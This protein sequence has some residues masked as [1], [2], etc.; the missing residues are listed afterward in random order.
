M[1]HQIDMIKKMDAKGL[2][3]KVSFDLPFCLYV[4]DDSYEVQMYSYT[5][6][7]ST[8]RKKQEHI[9]P[10]VGIEEATTELVRD[11]YGRL[12]YTSVDITL[13][14]QA[15]LERETRRRIKEG[16]I[17]TESPIIKIS[18]DANEL[19]SEYSEAAL[20]EGMAVANYFIKVY[21]EVTH[22]FHIKSFPRDEVYR[23][24]I[25]WFDGSEFLGGVEHGSFGKGMTLEPVGLLPETD[26]KFRQR[27]KVYSLTPL[28][29]EV[30]MNARDYLDLG[31]YRMAV[32]ESRTCVE[33]VIDQL[34]QAHFT[35]R[36]TSVEKVKRL[37]NV[38]RKDIQTIEDALEKAWIN[39]KL[40]KGLKHVLGKGLDEDFVLWE[41][42]LKAKSNR[43]RAVHRAV[44]VSE[45]D[46]KDAI[47][48]LSQIFDFIIK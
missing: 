14:G 46:A 19:I 11:R 41:K 43:E 38:R 6:T 33:V 48:T 15:I 18:L 9:D 40:T 45:A 30:A 44:D 23:A 26:Q 7:V 5:A 4:K 13:P 12:R 3:V 32:I 17:Q 42:W 39:N 2:K 34:L 25:N 8:K 20:E 35:E 10:R 21:R 22:D 27:L 29:T 31:N 28:Y 24:T 47:E 16:E 1:H 36:G 37:L